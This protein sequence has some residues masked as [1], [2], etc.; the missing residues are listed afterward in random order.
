MKTSQTSS[1]TGTM[2]GAIGG[3]VAGY[4][5]WLL[6]FSIVDDNAAVGLGRRWVARNRGNRG[7]PS[8]R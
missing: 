2:M 4:V 5:L 3:I 6:A 8:C 7:R 1:A